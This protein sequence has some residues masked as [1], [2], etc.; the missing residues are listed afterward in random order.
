MSAFDGLPPE[1]LDSILLRAAWHIGGPVHDLTDVSVDGG[2]RGEHAYN[3][4]FLPGFVITLSKRVYAVAQPL[5]YRRIEV[6]SPRKLRAVRRHLDRDP[7]AARRVLSLR[8]HYADV[9]EDA[10]TVVWRRMSAAEHDESDESDADSFVGMGHDSQVGEEV[11]ELEAQFG[12]DA[13]ALIALCRSVIRIELHELEI[14][15]LFAE[16]QSLPP[17]CSTLILCRGTISGLNR[18]LA[19]HPSIVNVRV[20]EPRVTHYSPAKL[21]LGGPFISRIAHLHLGHG[22][23]LASHG[24]TALSRLRCEWEGTGVELAKQLTELTGL[25]V[26]ELVLRCEDPGVRASGPGGL[27]WANGSASVGKSDF[28]ARRLGGGLVSLPTSLRELAITFRTPHPDRPAV[29]GVCA[30]VASDLAE[31][32]ATMPPDRRLGGCSSG[33]GRCPNPSPIQSP[34]Q[35]SLGCSGLARMRRSYSGGRRKCS[36]RSPSS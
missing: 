12:I 28:F 19:S 10:E 14:N 33:I 8:F 31:V 11:G 17:S 1:I 24:A 15:S 3:A 36:L 29:V 25:R 18:T 23:V 9:E 2:E 30:A 22:V 4:D 16:D 21:T 6:T 27:A 7:E 13:G 34:S 26:L 35:R 20:E 32:V 5:L